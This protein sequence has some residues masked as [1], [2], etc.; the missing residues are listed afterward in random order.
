VASFREEVAASLPDAKSR[1]LAR[2]LDFTPPNQTAREPHGA[3]AFCWVRGG[4]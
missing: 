2:V 3:R 1:D 4:I